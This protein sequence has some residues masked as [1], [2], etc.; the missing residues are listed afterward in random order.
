MV[1]EKS[2]PMDMQN[3]YIVICLFLVLIRNLASG[4]RYLS[5]ACKDLI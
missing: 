2:Y 3:E 1:L 4:K 5:E